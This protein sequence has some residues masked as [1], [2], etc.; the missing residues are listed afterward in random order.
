MSVWFPASQMRKSRLREI[1]ELTT[2]LTVQG[3]TSLP[4]I[5]C[6]SHDTRLLLRVV[7][8]DGEEV[9]SGLV[10]SPTHLRMEWTTG[11]SS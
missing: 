4:S 1:K 2:V 5:Q 6:H 8:K 3:W 9:H 10:K 11:L 7:G